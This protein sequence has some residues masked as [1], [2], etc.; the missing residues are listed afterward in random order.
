[1]LRGQQCFQPMALRL[2][3]LRAEIGENLRDAAPSDIFDERAP[4]LVRCLPA[5]SVEPVRQFDGRKVIARLL[6]QRAGSEP[7]LSGDSV[8]PR[9]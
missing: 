7:I 3:F 1:M 5:L 8:V 4:L 2:P 6:L 9:V